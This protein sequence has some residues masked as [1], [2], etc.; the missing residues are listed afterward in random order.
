MFRLSAEAVRFPLVAFLAL[1]LLNTSV[2][3]SVSTFSSDKYFEIFRAY[4]ENVF[5]T[6]WHGTVRQGSVRFS[7]IEDVSA[8]SL[9]PSI[10]V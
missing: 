2:G 7:L 5:G 9:F 6:L 4:I 8:P 1:H 3:C 10:Y